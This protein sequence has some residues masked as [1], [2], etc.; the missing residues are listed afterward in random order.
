MS[1]KRYAFTLALFLSICSLFVFCGVNSSFAASGYPNKTIE[2]I[3]TNTAGGGSDIFA[4]TLVKIIEDKKL[5]PVTINVINMPGGNNSV[6]WSFVANNRR[7]DAYTITPTSSSFWTGP[8][9]GLSPVSYKNFTHIINMLEDPRLLVVYSDSPFKSFKDLID[10]AKENPNKLSCGGSGGRSMDEI[11]AGK[12]EEYTQTK[13]KFVPF[14]NA[15]ADPVTTL[16]GGHIDFALL[17]I[18]E[19]GPQVE[20]GKLR[21]LAVSS[22][23]RVFGQFADIPTMKEEGFDFVITQFRGV[24]APL[25][26][27]QEAVSFLENMFRKAIETPEWKKFVEQNGSTERVLI[28]NDY[29]KESETMD[30]LMSEILGKKQ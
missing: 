2:F 4:R 23:E 19:V 16:M 17:G 18:S 3:V 14:T 10:F 20:A 15:G 22:E 6:G 8:A 7:G 29:F 13:I 5:C 27:P 30:K 28:G 25:E 11:L 9:A 26:I 21:V 1:V 24:V 12:L